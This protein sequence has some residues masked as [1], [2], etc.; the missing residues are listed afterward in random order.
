MES[1]FSSKG[2]HK[3][4]SSLISSPEPRENG[5]KVKKRATRHPPIP[6]QSSPELATALWLTGTE[7]RIRKTRNSVEASLPFILGNQTSTNGSWPNK[8]SKMANSSVSESSDKSCSNPDVYDVKEEKVAGD[9]IKC[10]SRDSCHTLVD[11]FVGCDSKAK[12]FMNASSSRTEHG[13][14][15]ESIDFLA[16]REE[17]AVLHSMK[18]NPHIFDEDKGE[19]CDAVK[20]NVKNTSDSHI[21]KTTKSEPSD[22]TSD[23][24]VIDRKPVEEECA[25]DSLTSALELSSLV[26]DI[27]RENA[28]I[29]SRSNCDSSSIS[30]VPARTSSSS[31][32]TSASST[33]SAHEKESVINNHAMFCNVDLMSH[34]TLKES[35]DGAS[36]DMESSVRSALLDH[37]SYSM[38]AASGKKPAGKDDILEEDEEDNN[39]IVSRNVFLTF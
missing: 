9:S 29:F 3:G 24:N 33:N 28:V 5:K 30:E 1:S 16:A 6:E 20:A 27:K 12:S 36:R 32:K 38:S 11:E 22:A 18:K 21:I 7:N 14:S 31:Q 15:K 26:C 34:T 19:E 25:G 8:R 13:E 23:H 2:I 35:D 4:N 17:P 39:E 37:V 10:E